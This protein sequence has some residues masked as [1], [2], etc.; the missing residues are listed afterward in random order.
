MPH[1]LAIA[2]L[3]AQ[4]STVSKFAALSRH[5]LLL[6]HPSRVRSPLPRHHFA[7]RDTFSMSQLQVATLLAAILIAAVH[8]CDPSCTLSFCDGGSAFALGHEPDVPFSSA[9][10]IGKRRLTVAETGEAVVNGAPISTL[11]ATNAGH[12]ART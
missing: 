10:C 4:H 5:A 7:R 1:C 2:Y 3:T 6:L 9:V 11:L 12:F 8:S